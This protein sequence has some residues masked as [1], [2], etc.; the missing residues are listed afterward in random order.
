MLGEGCLLVSAIYAQPKFRSWQ[1]HLTGSPA[2]TGDRCRSGGR[3]RR[4]SRALYGFCPKVQNKHTAD[5]RR[6]GALDFSSPGE[7][8][9]STIARLN[10]WELLIFTGRW[11]WSSARRAHG[12]RHP[13]GLAGAGAK[14]PYGR[15]EA[16]GEAGKRIRKMAVKR[17]V[18]SAR[19]LRARTLGTRP[20]RKIDR[21]SRFE[22]HG[23]R[24]PGQHPKVLV[25][26]RAPRS[27]K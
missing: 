7:K 12:W 18:F 24:W 23:Q 25:F 15:N 10:L 11:P 22:H 16:R 4:F 3:L 19:C 21:P 9:C 26:S 5:L 20:A 27:N 2:K 13:G 17:R 14:W 8:D 1:R 6:F